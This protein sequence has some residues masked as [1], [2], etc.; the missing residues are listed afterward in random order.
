MLEATKDPAS[1]QGL[2]RP[3]DSCPW[4]RF[5]QYGCTGG[6][7]EHGHVEIPIEVSGPNA[8][9]RALVNFSFTHQAGQKF[10]AWF[11]DTEP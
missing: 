11:P 10:Q 1:Y 6:N 4:V 3:A 8:S 2:G 9:Y 5:T 7:V